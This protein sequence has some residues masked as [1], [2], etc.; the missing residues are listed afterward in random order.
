MSLFAII[1]LAIVGLIGSLL[2]PRLK[3]RYI[4]DS[5]R[6]IT[7]ISHFWFGVRI[8]FVSDDLTG[9][10]LFLTFRKKT[11]EPEQRHDKPK[12]ERAEPDV[13][14]KPP[15]KTTAR[16]RIGKPPPKA[17]TIIKPKKEPTEKESPGWRF[18]WQERQL[19][20]KLIRHV[21]STIVKLIKAFSIDHFK[22]H[23]TIATPDP[24]TSGVMYG[25]LS[26]LLAL[27]APPR[28]S[29]SLGLDFD[30]STLSGEVAIS[31][32][33]RPITILFIL[34]IEAIRLPWFRI[35]HLVRDY[36]AA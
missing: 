3:F 28:R 25:Y 2:I 6:H 34:L 10:I 33:V 32:S 9:R 29:I 13:E 15:Q 23:L 1:I 30:E 14:H 4:Y 21:V 8:D 16:I 36:R 7:E 12:R 22:A 31:I 19:I 26:P 17:K 20:G 11:A 18:F 27:N 35:Y 24:M 5:D